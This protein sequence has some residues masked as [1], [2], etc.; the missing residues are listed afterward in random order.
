MVQ[1]WYTIE[2]RASLWHHPQKRWMHLQDP[3]EHRWRR[4]S[5]FVLGRKSFG[6]GDYNDQCGRQRWDWKWWDWIYLTLTM[7]TGGSFPP[8]MQSTKVS[9]V[10]LFHQRCK[11]ANRLVQ[12]ALNPHLS[13]QTKTRWPHSSMFNRN[14]QSGWLWKEWVRYILQWIGVT[15]G[16]LVIR[17]LKYSHM[18]IACIYRKPCSSPLSFMQ[19]FIIH[20]YISYNF[21]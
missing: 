5:I 15:G 17:L 1:R 14:A 4:W 3:R 16:I 7:V 10:F 19:L 8:F 13:R 11:S 20:V 9:F 6:T 21:I 2:E 18:F 12:Q